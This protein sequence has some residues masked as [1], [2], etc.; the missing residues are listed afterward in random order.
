MT[1]LFDNLFN[2]DAY[3]GVAER[4]RAR[5]IYGFTL[6]VMVLFLVYAALAPQDQAGLTMIGRMSTDFLSVFS[7]VGILV[8]GVATL[9]FTRR[10]RIDLGA[11]GPL[12]MWL[13]SGVPLGYQVHFVTAD[14][15]ATLLVLILIG[16]LFLRARGLAIATVLALLVLLVSVL[17]YTPRL[18]VTIDYGAYVGN[19][20]AL[21]FQVLGGAGLLYLFLRGARIET[22]ASSASAYEDRMRLATITTQLAQRIQRRTEL[23][24]LLNSAIAD[25]LRSYAD[26]YHAQIFLIDQTTNDAALAASTGEVGEMLL[27]RHHKLAVGSRS[28]IGQ[29]TSTG[30]VIV[31]R[32]ESSDGVHRRNEF[33]PD[34]V[35]EAAF[36]LRLG[37]AVIGALDLQ[38]RITA[39]FAEDDLPVFQSLADNIAVAIDNARLFEET[40]ARLSENQ[41]LVEQMRGAVREVERLNRQLTRQAWTDYLGDQGGGL[42]LDVDFEHNVNQRNDAWTPTLDEAVRTNHLVEKPSSDGITVSLPLRVRSEVIGAMEFELD[43][44]A[45]TP[46]DVNLLQAVA[47]R[48]GL[49][50][51]NVRLYEETRQAAD[52]EQR[53]NDIAARFQSVATVDE[54]LRITLTELS[55]TLGADGGSIRLGR[56]AEANG[57]NA[58]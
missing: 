10:G 26:I 39:A 58:P 47:D 38:S 19:S 14:A 53:I 35:V 56:F 45:L 11:Y 31:A 54:L 1:T 30:Q 2:T 8:V 12:L 49:A 42:S 15:G 24:D 34:T 48:F 20:V 9:V 23:N 52:Q 27:Q 57:E 36:P 55:D 5:L 28:V 7:I 33:L 44:E 37:D 50:V 22:I 25:I 13:L 51:E 41:G 16:S 29:V 21:A 18:D 3:P 6:I 43:G 40:E 17:T 46:E 4:D 32:A